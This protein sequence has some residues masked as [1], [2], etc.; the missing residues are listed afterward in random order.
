[1]HRVWGFGVDRIMCP[2]D[3]VDLSPVRHLFPH[4]PS[5]VFDPLPSKEI[6]VLV[7]MNFFSLHP[8][9]GQGRNCAENLK[10][11]HSKFSKGWVVAGSHPAFQTSSAKL[12][13]SALSLVKVA[14][15][16]IK[17]EFTVGFWEG[18]NM[19]VLPPKRCGRCMQCSEC[20]DSALIHSRKEQDEL[21][22][23]RNSIRIEDGQLKVSY[24]FI[25][26]PDCL[27][28][29]RSVVVSMAQKLESRLEKKDLVGRYNDEFQKYIDRGVIVP[30]SQQEL[31]E[32]CGPINYITHFGVEQPGS[33]TTKFRLVSHSSLKNGARSLNDCMP[34]GPN[35][36]NSMFAV[37]IRFRCYEAGLVF[38]LTKAYNSMHT[39]I[40]EKHLRRLV[41]RFSPQEPWQD[42]G[43]ATVAFG[44]RPAATLL[45]LCKDIT[46]DAG[47][48]IDPVAAKKLKQDSYVD[49][50]CTGGSKAEVARMMGQRLCDG[51]YSGTVCKIFSKGSLKVKVMVASEEQDQEAKDL[52]GNKV[53]G[54]IWEATTDNMGVKFSVNIS[55]RKRKLK[56]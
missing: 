34:K 13:S 9:G 20:K 56:N 7:G 54:Y 1:M 29:N 36:L 38:D 11:L 53:L 30:L 19:G 3:P 51:S 8:S 50:F 18:E 22:L 23:L 55:G 37:T 42:Y 4:I 45:E 35:S 47:H 24:P 27:P 33:V 2:P 44:D 16:E 17:P 46:V 25:K 32:Y 5:N 15:V 28:N 52:L 41:W 39:G 14:R 43:F 40:V 26:N 31:A 48:D 12:T 21:E 49:D 10:V 6:D